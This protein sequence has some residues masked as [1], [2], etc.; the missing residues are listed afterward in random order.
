MADFCR[1]YDE[2]LWD[3]SL[4]DRIILCEGHGRYEALNS[5]GRRMA[6]I[7]PAYE[8]GKTIF[9]TEPVPFDADLPMRGPGIKVPDKPFRI[10]IR[11][12]NGDVYKNETFELMKPALDMLRTTL[13]L[14][15]SLDGGLVS[16]MKIYC[17]VRL[18]GA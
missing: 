13:V 15:G 16:E 10:V 14:M 11:M 7:A 9:G 1:D 2:K 18:G 4:K 12:P 17:T 3:E 5:D 8:S 6:G